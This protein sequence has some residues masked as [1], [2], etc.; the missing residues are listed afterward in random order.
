MNNCNKCASCGCKEQK[1]TCPRPVLSIEPVPDEPSVLKYNVN[2]VTTY[3]DYAQLVK[4]TETDTT[5]SIDQT[6][7]ALIYRAERHTDSISHD[8]LGSILHLSDIGDVSADNIKNNSFLV[9]NNENDC[10]QGC[11]ST[12]SGYQAWNADENLED[13]MSTIMGFDS[14]D[15]PV[16]LQE[17]T[18][19]GQHYQL[20]WR[21]GNKAGWAQPREVATPPV[22][23]NNYAYRL[24][25]DPT[26]HEI[27]CVKENR[28]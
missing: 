1:C 19:T 13:S 8:L 15:S 20:S 22:D 2:G 3:Y 6:N 7:R 5:L 17:P 18:H 14:N 10:G 9:Y 16:A 23:A 11:Q 25:V 12:A 24:Y 26:T 28:A 21:A 27:V 4:D